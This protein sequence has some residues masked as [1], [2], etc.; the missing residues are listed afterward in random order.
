MIIAICSEGPHAVACT[1]EGYSITGSAYESDMLDC[2]KGGDVEDACL[3]VLSTFNPHFRVIAEDS[4]GSYFNRLATDEE[5][6]LTC[7]AI[8]L[9]SET[10]FS[11]VKTAKMYLIWEA[12]S[13]V[14]GE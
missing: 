10:D 7:E 1:D 6:Q 11:D 12:A 4:N 2:T 13:S 14:E 5:L 8:Y 9:E 3:Y